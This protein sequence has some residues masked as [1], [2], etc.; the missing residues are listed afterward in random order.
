MNFF[1][2]YSH[3]SFQRRC[4]GFDAVLS[5]LYCFGGNGVIECEHFFQTSFVLV[6]ICYIAYD[7]F[8]SITHHTLYCAV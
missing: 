1:S 4:G 7:T 6:Y 5:D 8:M 2:I 3:F